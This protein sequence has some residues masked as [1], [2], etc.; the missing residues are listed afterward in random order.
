MVCSFLLTSDDLSRVLWLY[1][2]IHFAGKIKR[3]CE[4]ELGIVSQCISPKANINKR[5]F[6]NVALKINV[7]VSAFFS[8]PAVLFTGAPKIHS[9][10]RLICI[11]CLYQVGGRNTVLEKA[12]MKTLPFVSDIPTI[13]FGADVTHPAPGED[14]SASIAAV[15]SCCLCI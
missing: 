10:W 14:S 13:I 1:C 5:Y 6:E 4:T 15:S 11:Y 8:M 3:L 12:V 2:A 9:F 7:K